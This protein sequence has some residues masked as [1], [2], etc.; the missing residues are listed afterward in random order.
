VDTGTPTID[1]EPEGLDNDKTSIFPTKILLATDVLVAA[2]LV[3]AR[4]FA[5][6]RERAWA[7]YSAVSGVVVLITVIL[8][9][10]GFPRTEG[11]GELG[12]LFQRISVV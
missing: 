6:R 10:Y 12:G 4:W 7:F 3:L 11:L 2:C 9:S 1:H 5:A 8:A